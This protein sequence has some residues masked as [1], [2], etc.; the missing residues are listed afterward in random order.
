MLIKRTYNELSGGGGGATR[1]L[2]RDGGV[3]ELHG[4]PTLN[5]FTIHDSA[6][7]SRRRN[8]VVRSPPFYPRGGP[9]W[10]DNY[11]EGPDRPVASQS[12]ETS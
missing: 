5:K 3:E 6:P 4:D 2:L 7:T 10:R 12:S 11:P 8:V 9:K 1:P